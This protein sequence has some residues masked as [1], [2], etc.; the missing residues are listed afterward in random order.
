MFDLILTLQATPAAR[1]LPSG[2]CSGKL[3]GQLA[4]LYHGLDSGIFSVGPLIPV[5]GAVV[6]SKSDSQIWDKTYVALRDYQQDSRSS[7]SKGVSES[8]YNLQ[9]TM[10]AETR[11]NLDRTQV[12]IKVLPDL[13]KSLGIDTTATI[14]SLL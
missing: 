10:K 14:E 2:T 5:L 8:A 9:Q 7:S 6:E 11:A 1:L 3:R 4:L 13:I 12:A